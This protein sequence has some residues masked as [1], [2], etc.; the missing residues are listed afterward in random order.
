MKN[1]ALSL[2]ILLTLSCKDSNSHSNEKSDLFNISY[3]DYKKVQLLKDYKKVSDTSYVKE[4]NE[5]THR[6]T[7]LRK[8]DK[9]LI[10]F[11]KIKFDKENK[12]VHTILDTLQI[13][14][15]NHDQW[16]TIGYC[17]MENTLMEELIAI[18]EKTEKDTIQKID[19]AWKANAQTNKIEPIK[20]VE[21][22]ICLN[23][24]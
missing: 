21:N 10:L 11:S 16:I 22:I 23:E 2:L 13:K 18:V 1:L 4:G 17:E 15:L 20:N 12:E 24:H 7:E 19:K 14:N 3:S 5:P 8:D 6:I 9:T